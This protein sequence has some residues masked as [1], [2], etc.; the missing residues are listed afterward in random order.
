M[1]TGSAAEK[2]DIVMLLHFAS[3]ASGRGWR[4]GTDMMGGG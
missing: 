3:A 1:T 2:D 4:Y